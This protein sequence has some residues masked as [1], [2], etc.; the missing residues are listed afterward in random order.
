MAGHACYSMLNL[1]VGLVL[2]WLTLLGQI[3]CYWQL[4]SLSVGRGPT[5]FWGGLYAQIFSNFY[6]FYLIFYKSKKCELQQHYIG[7]DHRT[8]DVALRDLTSIQSPIS[9]VRLTCLPQGWTN[10]GAIFHEDVTFLLESEIPHVTW[11]YIDD[12]SIKGPT[13]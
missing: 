8:L 11:L 7:Y 12:C 13:T 2:R 6:L 10:A 4:R 1:F 3:S 9:A 5:G